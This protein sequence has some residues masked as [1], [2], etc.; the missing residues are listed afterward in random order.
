MNSLLWCLYTGYKFVIATTSTGNYAS[1]IESCLTWWICC[2]D[3]QHVERAWA[4][5]WEKIVQTSTDR[6]HSSSFRTCRVYC[7]HF[8]FRVF[9]LLATAD[10]ILRYPQEDK[11]WFYGYIRNMCNRRSGVGHRNRGGFTKYKCF[12]LLIMCLPVRPII[13]SITSGMRVDEKV[14]IKEIV[15]F[16]GINL[17]GILVET[18]PSHF[19]AS[20][21]D[22][23]SHRC[24]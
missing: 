5:K 4:Q 18:S 22:C 19:M 14:W 3:R 13:S 16:N 20:V 15:F 23:L 24:S 7:V 9:L 21:K 8:L 6:F 17:C 10:R 1:L 11:S 2:L 12:F